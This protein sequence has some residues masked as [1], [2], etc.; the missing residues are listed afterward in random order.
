M[1]IL[2]LGFISKNIEFKTRTE[3][4]STSFQFTMEH[5]S[6][7]DDFAERAAEFRE[8]HCLILECSDLAKAN[9]VIGRAQVAKQLAPQSYIIVVINSKLLVEDTRQLKLSGASLVMLESEYIHTSKLE[10][11]T[12]QVIRSS[13]IPIKPL[14]LISGTTLPFSLFHLLPV[15]QR[16]LKV[17]N[18]GTLLDDAFF[19][20]YESSGDLYFKRKNLPAW[21]QYCERQRSNN[22]EG[23]LRQARMRFLLLN[24][25]F[26]DLTL[27]ISDQSAAASFALGKDL[28]TNCLS[29]AESLLQA[30]VAIPEPWSLINNSAI[31]DFGSAER[32]PAI[33]S[34]SGLLSQRVQIGEAREVLISAL[35]ADLGYLE[36]S[37][38]TTQ[39]IRLNRLDQFNPE[40][41]QEYE[42]HPIYS[43]NQC[44]SRKL[45]LSESVKNM[46]LQSHERVDRKGFPHRPTPEKLNQE[47]FLLQLSW[48]LDSLSQIR[49]GE[50]RPNIGL[51]KKQ[52]L[53]AALKNPGTYPLSFILKMKPVLNDT[54]IPNFSI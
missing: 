17:L 21:S 44:L 24:Q 53:D 38:S 35:L 28:F 19:K 25:S 12:S 7:I 41:K 6:S 33:A 50:A 16:F 30:L 10:F 2:E 46:I 49:M 13:F 14:D 5:F 48:E 42:K 34:Y 23:L 9:D 8:I 22:S 31:G 47:A 18:P 51:V 36:L 45:P 26:L 40:E 11:V 3:T 39:K 27:L 37:P 29:F 1:Q 43:L 32:A 52:V 54:S 4:L 15:N 20:K